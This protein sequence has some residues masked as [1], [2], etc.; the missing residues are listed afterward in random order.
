MSS[1]SI[2]VVIPCFRSETLLAEAIDSVLGQTENDWELILVDNNASEETRNVIKDYLLRFPDKIR[3]IHEPAQ[4]NSFARNRGIKEAI[5]TFIALLDDDDLMY[6]ERLRL[7]RELLEK[8]PEVSL[9]HGRLDYVSFDNVVV[10]ANAIGPTFWNEGPELLFARDFGSILPST[11]FFRKKTALDI[12]IF[13]SHFNPAYLEDTDFCMRMAI[14]GEVVAVDRPIIRF[15]WASPSFLKKKRSNIVGMYRRLLNQDYFFC[16]VVSRMDVSAIMKDRRTRRLFLKWKAKWLREAGLLFM[17]IPGGERIARS[18]LLRAF[19]EAPL[20]FKNIRHYIRSF[21][22]E[23]I[24]MRKYGK[25]LFHE[26]EIPP[27]IT[28]DFIRSLFS[29]EHHCK[30]CQEKRE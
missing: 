25:N 10:E 7:Q 23:K 27:E 2:S 19:L 18:F 30:Y 1:P 5:G 13:D 16:K 12:G 17:P 6:P 24:K 4:G 20:E 3:C 29:G 21:Y 22:P 8:R 26:G 14:A 28:K 15:R 11:M 9:C